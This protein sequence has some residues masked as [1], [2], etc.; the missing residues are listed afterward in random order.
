MEFSVD[1]YSCINSE[2]ENK[3]GADLSSCNGSG[4]ENGS[5]ADL[6]IRPLRLQRFWRRKRKRRRMQQR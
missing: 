2:E 5:G 4:E 3:R 1:L 6:Y